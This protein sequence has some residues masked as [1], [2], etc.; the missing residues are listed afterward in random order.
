MVQEVINNY[1]TSGLPLD[2]IYLDIPYMK[3]YEDFTVD[4]DKFPNLTSLSESLHKNNQ[5]IIV[6]ID[7]AVSADNTSSPYYQMGA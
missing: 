4:T 7:A 3:N 1:N 2:T 5:Q 6:I